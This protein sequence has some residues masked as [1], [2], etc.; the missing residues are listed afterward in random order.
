MKY[1]M[2]PP[3]WW[4]FRW[5]PTGDYKKGTGLWHMS[6]ATKKAS[7]DVTTLNASMTSVSKTATM[8][9]V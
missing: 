7:M 6:A 2:I 4:P 9:A 5:W 3:I 8:T 1:G